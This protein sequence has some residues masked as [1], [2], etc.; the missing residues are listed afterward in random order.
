[1]TVM[2]ADGCVSKV[3]SLCSVTHEQPLKR[4]TI[5]H[6]ACLKDEYLGTKNSTISKSGVVEQGL[7]RGV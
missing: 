7:E 1:M 6:V 4:A 3:Y 2:A 5:E